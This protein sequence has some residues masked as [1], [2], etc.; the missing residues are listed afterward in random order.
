MNMDDTPP[1]VTPKDEDTGHDLVIYG[2]NQ[3]EPVTDKQR[4][5]VLGVLFRGES[6]P[7]YNFDNAV[8]LYLACARRSAELGSPDW[9]DEQWAFL[10]LIIRQCKMV[11][12]K[13][14]AGNFPILVQTVEGQLRMF[15]NLM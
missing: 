1:P 13:G 8:R 6:I 15:Y 12:K 3:K 11:A 7:A 5:V 2:V 4:E 9:T 14:H 10:N